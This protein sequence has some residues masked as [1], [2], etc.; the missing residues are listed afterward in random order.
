VTANGV[1]TELVQHT[2]SLAH[3][4]IYWTILLAVVVVGS[5]MIFR[6]RDVV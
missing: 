5:L 6:R 1:T 3:G 4:A 2:V